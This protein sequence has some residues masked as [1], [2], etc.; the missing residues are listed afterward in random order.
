MPDE[1]KNKN[2]TAAREGAFLIV[3]FMF[4][5]DLRVLTHKLDREVWNSEIYETHRLLAHI[6]KLLMT[7]DEF[8]SLSEHESTEAIGTR[9]VFSNDARSS[10]KL[11][12]NRTAFLTAKAGKKEFRVSIPSIELYLFETRVG[13]L[14]FEIQS[15]KDLPID[16][17]I[18]NNYYIK[19]ISRHGCELS[20]K[21]GADKHDVNLGLHELTLKLLEDIEVESYFE[22]ENGEI[23]PVRAI[24]YSFIIANNS[25]VE[26]D[27]WEKEIRENIFR[28]R[29]SF[30]ESYRA[31]DEE[32]NIKSNNETLQL[33]ENSLWGISLEGFANF[34]Y[35]LKN[36]E[37]VEAINTTNTFFTG[38][39]Y[40]NLRSTYLYMYMLSLHQRYA[41]LSYAT[42]VARL[43]QFY[44]N[45]S[46]SKENLLLR[47]EITSFTLRCLFKQVSSVTHHAKLYDSIQKVL[48]IKELL[49]ELE[50]ET[51][52]LSSMYDYIENGKENRF[53]NFL[54]IVTTIVG[55]AAAT[56]AILSISSNIFQKKLPPTDSPLLYVTLAL[57]SAVWLIVGGSCIYFMRTF[58]VRKKL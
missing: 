53:K 42:K 33:F 19:N 5:E 52:A 30:K 48:G 1:V 21:T 7:R 45:K 32:Y 54:Y 49:D 55:L 13:F 31:S 17:I 20:Y 40:G 46:L 39:Y 41:L 56:N 18:D 38:T 35:L 43:S 3:P 14:V 25:F 15:E 27:N 28:M 58:I 36:P 6:N 22:E 57:I 24:V 16:K 26:R 37:E 8:N 11:P 9:L 44:E 50:T 10:F 12:K 2:G 47:K 29:R 23:A 34:V 4:K 51:K